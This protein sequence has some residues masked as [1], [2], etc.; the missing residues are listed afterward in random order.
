[1]TKILV[2]GLINLETS[3]KIESFPITYFPVTYPFFGINSTISGVGYNISKA[4][5]ILGD[6]VDLL[7]I[8][9]NDFIGIVFWNFTY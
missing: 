3:V 5:S 6:N 4:L 8:I 2:A 9:G 7:S 1:M